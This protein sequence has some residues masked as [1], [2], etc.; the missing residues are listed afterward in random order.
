MIGCGVIGAAIAYELSQVPGLTITVLDKQPPAQGATGAA[1]GV[2][3]GVI[4]HK[5][6]G[7][8]WRMRQ[9]SIQ[10]YE[11]LIP[12]L[13]ALTGRQIPFNRQGILILLVPRLPVPRQEPGNGLKDLADW[14]KLVEIRRSQGWKLEI[15]DVA[16]VKSSCPTLDCDQIAAAVYS[17]QDR[18]VEPVALTL[19]MVDAAQRNGVTFH[20]GVTVEGYYPS[21]TSI[22]IEMAAEASPLLENVDWLVVAAGNGSSSI[23]SLP[24]PSIRPVLGQALH[25]RLGHAFGCPDFQPVI[26]GEDVHIVPVGGGDYWVGATVEFPTNGDEVIAAPEK[27]EAVR[28][29]AIAFCPALAEAAVVR[30]WSGLRPRP[31]G[32]PAPVIGHLQG[33]SHVLL[34]TGHY[35]NGVLLAPATAEGIREIIS[36]V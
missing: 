32:T 26:T 10:R 17:P 33:K 34:A 6:K 11:T 27:L 19:A 20:F 28:Q 13:E 2:M 30:T 3:M 8:A 22:K 36:S 24:C 29:K 9:T 5:I 31:E 18:Q 21:T 14:E 4:S 16:Q 23:S 35:R 7:N 1:L 15:W 25:L 12:E